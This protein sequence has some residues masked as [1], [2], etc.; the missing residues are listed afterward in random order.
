M[1]K[2]AQLNGNLHQSGFGGDGTSTKIT[3]TTGEVAYYSNW[4]TD[5][6]YALMQF[7][8]LS[9]GG[10]TIP[11]TEGGF[12]YRGPAFKSLNAPLQII[13]FFNRYFTLYK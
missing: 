9:R 6:N 10:H 4:A 2:W 11:G 5:F 1:K 7:Y 8:S 13:D 12:G 3:Y